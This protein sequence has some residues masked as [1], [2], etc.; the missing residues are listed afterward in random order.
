[1]GYPK[2]RADLVQRPAARF[3]FFK[4][5]KQVTGTPPRS[6]AKVYLKKTGSHPGVDLLRRSLVTEYYEVYIDDDGSHPEVNS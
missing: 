1:M 2:T 3:V 4:Y 5:T 6:E